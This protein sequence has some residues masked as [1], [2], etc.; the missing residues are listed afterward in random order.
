MRSIRDLVMLVAS[1]PSMNVI[2]HFQSEGA[3]IYFIIGGTMSE[4][5]LFFVREEKPLPGSFIIYNNFSGDISYSERLRTDPNI[6]SI[7][8]VEV[9]SQDIIPPE[10]LSK[11]LSE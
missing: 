10:Q 9:S 5:F 2:Q 7:P 3:H 8:I 6:S 11:V 4:V 1:S